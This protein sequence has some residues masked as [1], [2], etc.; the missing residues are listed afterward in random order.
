[1]GEEDLHLLLKLLKEEK[2]F[3]LNARRRLIDFVSFFIQ[4]EHRFDDPRVQKPLESLLGALS[5]LKIV[6]ATHFFV[7]PRNQTG[8][9]LRHCLHPDYFVLE[10]HDISIDEHQFFL[11][12]ERQLEET[13]TKVV[14]AYET[15]RRQVRRRLRI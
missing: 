7:F 1:M 2:A 15:F 12:A 5:E 8:S 9:N 4:G 10:M 6:T 3:F 13:I 14:A 11:K